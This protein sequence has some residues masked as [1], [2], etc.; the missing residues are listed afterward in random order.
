MAFQEKP[1][2]GAKKLLSATEDDIKFTVIHEIL[3]WF[4]AFYDPRSNYKKSKKSY[5]GE[6]LILYE[7]GAVWAEQFM[8]G[9]KLNGN[10]VKQYL[11]TYLRSV[12][13]LDAVYPS[14]ETQTNKYSNQGYGM[15][16]MLYYF[17]SPISEMTAFGIDKT[18]IVDI[19]KKWAILANRIM[20]RRS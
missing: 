14:N 20:V 17:T 11:P 10:F 7:A 15:S 4:Q 19:Y 1:D 13:D 5:S 9:G 8:N 2:L 16:S 12:K 6:E 3:H 18:K